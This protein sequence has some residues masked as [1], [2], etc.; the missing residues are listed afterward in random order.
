MRTIL[1]FMAALLL[2]LCACNKDK[3]YQDSGTHDPAFKGTTLGYLDAVP[4]YFDSVAT[5]VRLAGM[6]EVFSRDT[7]TF[8][9]PTDRSVLRLVHSLNYELYRLGY[10]TVKVLSDVPQEIW[11]KYLQR[12]MFHGRNELKDYP[13]ID[14]NL[15]NTYPG[16]GYLSWNGT[17]M[18][19]G[20]V[21]HDDNGVKYV[22]YRQ[23]SIACIPDPARPRE[24]WIIDY[25]A[26]C[27]ITTYNGVV[28]TLTDDHY[29]FGFQADLFIA[30]MIDVMENGG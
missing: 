2:G 11:F 30:D 21:Y 5:I 22:G 17:P 18:N 23:L 26:S 20:V 7:L 16:Q 12:Y 13:Q 8:F 3:Y 14:Y 28:H 6:E 9:A 19:I 25:I 29:Y 27:N 15:L 24:N 1:C 4:F 10:D